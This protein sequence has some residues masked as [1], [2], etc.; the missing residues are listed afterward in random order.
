MRHMAENHRGQLG[1]W[2]FLCDDWI[3]CWDSFT[4]VSGELL[5][6]LEDRHSNYWQHHVQIPGWRQKAK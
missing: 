3:S 2:H 1:P 4:D 5:Y 6:D